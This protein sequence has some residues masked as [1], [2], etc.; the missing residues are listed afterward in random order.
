MIGIIIAVAVIVIAGI[1][2]AVKN[3]MDNEKR[4]EYVETYNQYLDDIDSLK[5]KCCKVLLML[6]VY[7]I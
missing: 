5:L 2:F 1:G 6:R 7:V 4:K 3:H